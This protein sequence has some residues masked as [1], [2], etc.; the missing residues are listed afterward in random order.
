MLL[1]NSEGI[2]VHRLVCRKLYLKVRK[3]S[4]Q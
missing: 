1:S 2:I 4:M 3:G